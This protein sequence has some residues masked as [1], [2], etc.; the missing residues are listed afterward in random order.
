MTTL[1]IDVRSADHRMAVVALFGEIDQAVAGP[2]ADALESALARRPA[3]V[4]VD[5][6]GLA[7]MDSSGARVLVDAD[8]AARAA[9]RRL[10]VIP[11]SGVPHRVIALLGLDQVLDLADD[12]ASLA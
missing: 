2:M 6:S 9:G 10:V 7:F 11:G 3:A 1:G 4:V 5:L 12:A 8:R